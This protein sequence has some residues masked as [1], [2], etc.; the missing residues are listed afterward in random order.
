MVPEVSAWLD[1][2]EADFK[3]AKDNIRSRNYYASVI[4]S[5]QCAEKGLKALF[6][7]IK[8]EVPPKIHDLVELGRLIQAPPEI[9]SPAS[10]LSG[11]YFSSRYP[12]AIPEI[13]A[14]YYTKEKAEQHLK[15]AEVI[16]RWA[17]KKIRS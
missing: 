5:Q 7:L 11:T 16:L 8:K 3:T 10:A 9:V 2:A 14:K 6:I 13:P 4:F 17:S 15:E 1:Q 12:D